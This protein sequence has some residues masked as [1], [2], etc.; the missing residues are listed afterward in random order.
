MSE[1][2]SSRSFTLFFLTL[3]VFCPTT[4]GRSDFLHMTSNG[5]LTAQKQ[6]FLMTGSVYGTVLHVIYD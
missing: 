2:V 1:I 5:T 3:P 4:T 6:H